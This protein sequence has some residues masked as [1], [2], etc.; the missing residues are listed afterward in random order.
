M[1]ILDKH[2]AH[3]PALDVLWASALCLLLCILNG[4]FGE[5]SDA[6]AQ[7]IGVLYLLLLVRPLFWAVKGI[8]W[9]INA[10]VVIFVVAVYITA[11]IGFKTWW[12]DE[13]RRR[14]DYEQSRAVAESLFQ[15]SDDARQAL[16]LP[17]EPVR[18]EN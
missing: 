11:A 13:M 7:L 3:V 18:S 8:R 2:S 15:D 9:G 12:M 16:G 1:G 17:G 6:V 5:S 10:A 14:H 4:I